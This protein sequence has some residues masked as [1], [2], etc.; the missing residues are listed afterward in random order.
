MKKLVDAMLTLSRAESSRQN[1]RLQPADLSDTVTDSVLRFEPVSFESGKELRYT[2]DEHLTVSGDS[3]KLE[4]LLGILLDN[5][6]KYAPAGT[7]IDLSLKKSGK[8]AALTVENCGEPIPEQKLKH[9]FDRFYRVDEARSGTE[10]FGL[11][12]SIAQSIVRLH[13]G[14]IRCESD[15]RS[16]R[17][18]VTIPLAKA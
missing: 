11:G 6:I 8:S 17:F 10:G 14:S 16:T 4:Q 2:I 1:I 12:L 9:L 18:I 13:R 3:E 5:A 7:P 15:S